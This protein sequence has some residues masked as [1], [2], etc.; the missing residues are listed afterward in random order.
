MWLW[1][2]DYLMHIKCLAK[3]LA[4]V[5]DS[6]TMLGV[7]LK[8]KRDCLCLQGTYLKQDSLRDTFNKQDK[9]KVREWREIVKDR[10]VWHAAVH[11]VAKS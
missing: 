11:G 4:S 6:Y 9:R 7:L 2:F 8:D 1:K 3:N 5:W 10:E